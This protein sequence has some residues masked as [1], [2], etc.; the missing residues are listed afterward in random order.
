MPY[1]DEAGLAHYD[2]KLKEWISSQP[3]K[4]PPSSLYPWTLT[5]KAGAVT[6]WPVGGTP[7]KPAVDFMFTETGPA[8]GTKAPDNPS[9]ITGVSSI[10]VTHCE[11]VGVDETAYTISL[12]GTYCG[13]SLDLATGVMTVTHQYIVLTGAEG[14]NW[15]ITNN[16]PAEGWSRIS[17]TGI[18]GA[19]AFPPPKGQTATSQVCTHLPYLRSY[20]GESTHFYLYDGGGIVIVF[21]DADITLAEWNSWLAAQYAN[22]TPV[23]FAIE[24]KNPSTTVQLTP[25]QILSL[26]QSDKYT[27]RLNTIYS[28]QT[29]V[30]VGYVKSPIREEFEL[31]QAIVG[32]GGDI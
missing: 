5:D 7:L 15:G 1:L 18:M 2:P 22:G 9:T 23:T 27:P 26:T 20:N 4:T 25:Q 30:Q 13:G 12:N 32:L 24:L 17:F 16:Q 28:D 11:S 3:V 10:T 8:E 29:S 6:C 14:Y 21:P 19:T 31:Q